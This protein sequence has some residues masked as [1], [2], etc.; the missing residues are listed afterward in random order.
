MITPKDTPTTIKICS[1]RSVA[2]KESFSRM[3]EITKLE[4]RMMSAYSSVLKSER[5][6]MITSLMI[7]SEKK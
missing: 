3:V 5:S 2:E 4:L 7:K 6:R 1:I